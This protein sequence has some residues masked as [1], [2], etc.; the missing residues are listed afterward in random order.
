MI[1]GTVRWFDDLEGVGIITPD[2]G[3]E[4]VLVHDSAIVDEGFHTLTDN[5]RVRFSTTRGP[6]GLRAKYVRPL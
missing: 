6:K 4:D 1:T 2:S 3:G 5:E